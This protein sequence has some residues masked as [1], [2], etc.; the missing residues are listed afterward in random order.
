MTITLLA[1]YVRND[2]AR[3]MLAGF[4]ATT[5]VLSPLWQQLDRALAD[6]PALGSVVARQTA[7]LAGSRLDRANLIAAIRAALAADA[8]GEADPLCYLRDE[9]DE[10][11]VMSQGPGGEHDDV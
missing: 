6:V 8:E 9:L 11:Q 10:W 7:E 5:P 4:A 2:E 1:V 3:R